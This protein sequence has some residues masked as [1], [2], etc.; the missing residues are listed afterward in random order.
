MNK[1]LYVIA[2]ILGGYS[3]TPANAL[4]STASSRQL[5]LQPVARVAPD[6]YAKTAHI[7]ALRFRGTLVGSRR[8][9][10]WAAFA[11]F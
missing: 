9:L 7:V 1:N 8:V 4:E 3:Y 5:R 6:S 10:P 11:D 2:L